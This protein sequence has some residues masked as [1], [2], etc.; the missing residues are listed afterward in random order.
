MAVRSYNLIVAWYPGG[1]RSRG[2]SPPGVCGAEDSVVKAETAEFGVQ[3]ES[4]GLVYWAYD[5]GALCDEKDD[6]DDPAAAIVR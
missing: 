6:V 3:V 5:G 4:T 2:L 1:P